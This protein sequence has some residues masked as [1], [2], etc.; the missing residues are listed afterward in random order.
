MGGIRVPGSVPGAQWVLRVWLLVLEEA[1]GPRQPS[2]C[3]S[4]GSRG[5]ASL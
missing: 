1:W 5:Q 2:G 4:W 3:K